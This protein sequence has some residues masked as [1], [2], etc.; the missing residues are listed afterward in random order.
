[1]AA[2]VPGIADQVGSVGSEVGRRGKGVVVVRPSA[3]RSMCRRSRAKG[4]RA[5]YLSSRSRLAES[6]PWMRTEAPPP[7]ATHASRGGPGRG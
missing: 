7:H 1:M 3:G 4:D 5:Q 2:W 6:E